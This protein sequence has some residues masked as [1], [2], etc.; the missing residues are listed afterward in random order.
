MSWALVVVEKNG[1]KVGGFAEGTASLASTSSLPASK[2]KDT[3]QGNTIE[4]DQR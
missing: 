1:F 3:K 2:H 4:R